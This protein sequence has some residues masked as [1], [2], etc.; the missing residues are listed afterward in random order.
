M[1]TQS[2]DYIWSNIICQ[3]RDSL[4]EYYLSKYKNDFHLEK[5]SASDLKERVSQQYELSKKIVKEDY[6]DKTERATDLIDQHKIASCFCKSLIDVKF[7]KY[8]IS[9]KDI[10]SDLALINY[11]LAYA[12]SLGVIYVLLV[13]DY[14]KQG[15][16]ELAQKLIRQHTLKVPPTSKGHDSYKKG[17]IKTLAINDM[18]GNGFDILTYADMMF[19]IEF[20]NKQLIEQF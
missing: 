4:Y 8:D 20:Y 14:Y 2:F 10:P 15:K 13:D 11:E 1:K 19:W 16:S 6:Y 12:V 18:Y 17:R 5:S 7:F 3:T 9:N